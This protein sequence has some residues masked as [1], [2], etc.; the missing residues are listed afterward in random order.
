MCV[1]STETKNNK[2]KKKKKKTERKKVETYTPQSPLHNNLP[3]TNRLDQGILLLKR[4]TEAIDIMSG[5]RG[6]KQ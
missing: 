2:K 3:L 1:R 6:E 4:T 5:G